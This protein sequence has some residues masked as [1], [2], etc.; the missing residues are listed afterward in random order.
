MPFLF[1]SP[2]KILGGFVEALMLPQPLPEERQ[3]PSTPNA[4]PPSATIVRE[5][6]G[7]AEAPT[8][9]PL[10]ELLYGRDKAAKNDDAAVNVGYWDDEIIKPWIWD[11][12]FT[13]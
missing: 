4:T 11:P 13:R 10:P 7:H 1:T 3:P 2:A 12:G 8:E 6:E 9:R 5:E